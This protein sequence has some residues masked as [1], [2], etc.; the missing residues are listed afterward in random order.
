MP[1]RFLF[2]LRILNFER[3]DADKGDVESERYVNNGIAAFQ[4]G[5]DLE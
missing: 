4:V 3:S 2:A 1:V 5:L